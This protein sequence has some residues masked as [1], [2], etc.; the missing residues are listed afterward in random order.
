MSLQ[1]LRASLQR[2]VASLLP[3]LSSAC[4]F[5]L[6]H[7]TQHRSFMHSGASSSAPSASSH[8]ANGVPAPAQ[9]LHHTEVP[10]VIGQTMA[11]HLATAAINVQ[12]Q[13]ALQ[14]ALQTAQLHVRCACACTVDC[15]TTTT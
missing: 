5:P 7:P 12:H 10:A 9:P 14:T 2:C 13:T 8:T 3:E 1:P 4:T 6:H 15:R 11:F